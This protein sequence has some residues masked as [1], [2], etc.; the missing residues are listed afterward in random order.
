MSRR[1]KVLELILLAAV[2]VYVTAAAAALLPRLEVPHYDYFDYLWVAKSF[3]QGELPASFK[4]G[5]L[6][7]ALMA[8]GATF[9][10]GADPFLR[11]ARAVSLAATPAAL[12]LMYAF[13]RRALGRWALLAVAWLGA[14]SV[15][16]FYGAQPI[17][18]MLFTALILG[19]LVAAGRGAWPYVLAG[20]AAAT[21]Y[22][23]VALVLALLAF[24]LRGGR[25]L[26]SGCYAAAALAPMGVWL[27]LSLF[28][29]GPVHP[30]VEQYLS[31]PASGWTFVENM[32]TLLWAAK[33]PAL[34]FVS[35]VGGVV[36]AGGAV[37]AAVR[38]GARYGA[39]AAFLAVYVVAH[40][41]YPWPFERFVLPVLPIATVGLW[42]GAR[43]LVRLAFARRWLRYA[44]GG[45]GFAAGVALLVAAA[46]YLA[47][48]HPHL[49]ATAPPMILITAAAAYGTLR[50]PAAW[51]RAAAALL[52]VAVG[53]AY[54]GRSAADA[55]KYV[56]LE[57]GGLSYKG[58]ADYL[59]ATGRRGRVATT[60]PWLLRY[61]LD[62]PPRRVVGVD[63][64]PVRRFEELA[65]ALKKAK[66]KFILVDSLTCEVPDPRCRLRPAGELLLPLYEGRAGP[67]YR[68]VA[69]ITRRYE[70]AYIYEL[71]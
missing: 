39:A 13:A 19:A 70:T 15:F 3:A 6:Y 44:L 12:L 64:L 58:A 55:R 8:L 65:G 18:E 54:V 5:P 60:T 33:P 16:A 68:L 28:R 9:A 27:A 31:Y 10:G 35:Y 57:Q 41:V 53:S 51:Y 2:V 67:P 20:L 59:I 63:A 4:R 24:D 26:R 42:V 11:A 61:Y 30:Y 1:E 45:A 47:G 62:G 22:E 23:A 48:G 69:T 7:P 32:A 71:E 66:V 29:A 21:R 25:R 17:C 52:L 46:L 37:Y 38:H 49:A 50:R 56:E 36:A 14:S 34:R 43:A 40:A